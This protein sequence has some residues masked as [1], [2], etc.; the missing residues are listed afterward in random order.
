MI[1]IGYGSRDSHINVAIQSVADWGLKL[2]CISSEGADLAIS[3]NQTRKAAI[4]VETPLKV[5]LAKSLFG[6]S[7]C[8][9]RDIFGGDTAEHNKVM[10]FFV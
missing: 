1:V 5:M 2:F 3:L 10:R 6:A 4:A 8:G 7:R 9:L